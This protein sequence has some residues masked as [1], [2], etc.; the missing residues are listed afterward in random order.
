MRPD[1]TDVDKDD[2]I[3]VGELDGSCSDI[4]SSTRC[5]GLALREEEECSVRARCTASHKAL[6]ATLVLRRGP[7]QWRIGLKQFVDWASKR[8]CLT[9]LI[10][11]T[12]LLGGRV[13]LSSLWT[14]PGIT[15]SCDRDLWDLWKV[16]ADEERELRPIQVDT[17]SHSGADS[18]GTPETFRAQA[19]CA[20][21]SS[22]S[23]TPCHVG[24]RELRQRTSNLCEPLWGLG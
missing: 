16:C 14:G 13:A 11:G 23:E 6:S 7:P 2:A 20:L 21:K 15:C 5:S 3:N 10:S 22:S 1:D 18:D 9:C 12:A 17:D 24:G 8:A 19:V 4:A